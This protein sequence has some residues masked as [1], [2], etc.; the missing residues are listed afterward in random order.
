MSRLNPKWFAK[1][2]WWRKAAGRPGLLRGFRGSLSFISAR[3]ALKAGLGLI[4]S[5][6]GVESLLWVEELLSQTSVLESLT[7][8]GRGADLAS[9]PAPWGYHRKA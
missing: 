6:Q 2:G 1:L 3:R 9:V 5:S 8:S 7:T 4:S